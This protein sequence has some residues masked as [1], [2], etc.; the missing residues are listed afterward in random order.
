MK[1]WSWL[2]LVF[3]VVVSAGP[4][5]AASPFELRRGSDASS[6][7]NI[8]SSSTDT[9]PAGGVALNDY[10]LIFANV[11]YSVTDNLQASFTTLLPIVRDFPLVGALS[12][13][14]R[15]LETQRVALALMPS[16]IFGTQGGDRAGSLGLE[17]ICELSLDPEGRFFLSGGFAAH[18][19]FAGNELDGL[20]TADGM[21]LSPFV[22]FSGRLAKHMKLLAELSL[23]LVADW[24]HGGFQRP[25]VIDVNYGVRFFGKSLAVDL[26]FIRP[27][28]L[29]GDL[30]DDFEYLVMGIP[31]LSFTYRF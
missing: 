19:V 4:A 7:R 16:V 5:L 8:L 22:G 1:R 29:S 12:L 15:L 3:L 23:P 10:Q 26:S 18:N 2:S 31:Y 28:L 30:Q 20:Q 24:N 21:L 11:S 25:E 6:D 9:L 13:K 14:A 17:A 27:V